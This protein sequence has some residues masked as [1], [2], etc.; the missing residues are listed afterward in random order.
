[1]SDRAP[2]LRLRQDLALLAGALV[3]SLVVGPKPY[4]VPLGVG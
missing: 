1:M 4:L 2:S 3:F